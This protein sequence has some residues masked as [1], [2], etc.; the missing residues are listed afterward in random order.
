MGTDRLFWGSDAPFVGM[1]DKVT[2]GQTVRAF[3]DWVPDPAQR[4]AIG[5][6]AHRFYFDR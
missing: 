3:T 4:N 1:E 5:E 2:Y 6:T